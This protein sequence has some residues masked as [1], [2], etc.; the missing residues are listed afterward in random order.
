M[1]KTM[2]THKNMLNICLVKQLRVI[3]FFNSLIFSKIKNKIK[4]MKNYKT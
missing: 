2:A 1:S 3:L 4:N